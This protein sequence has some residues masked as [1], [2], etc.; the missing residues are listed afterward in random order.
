MKKMVKMAGA[1]LL[2]IAF[3]QNS[4][5]QFKASA[6]LE[7]G[8]AL[9]DGY[10]LMYGASV[11]GEYLMGD[12]GGIT[13]QVGYIL[14]SVDISGFDSYSSAFLPMQLGYKYYFDSNESGIYLHGQIGIHMMM[15]SYEYTYENYDY[16]ASTGQLIITEEKISESN[17]ESYLSYAV[18]GG[19]LVNEHIDLGLRF[20]IV[21]ATGGSFNY[22]G[23]RAAYVF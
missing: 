10:G 16:D 21:S 4:N 9:E 20:N 6:G 14:N 23:A 15:V 18:G 22:I 13:A 3:A 1:L 2:V 11:G 5:A 17:S 19:F 8:F 12:N 7:L